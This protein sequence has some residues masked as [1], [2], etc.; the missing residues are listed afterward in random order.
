MTI[1]SVATIA[2][3]RLTA[4]DDKQA[5]DD[6]RYD[7]PSGVRV[8]AAFRTSV[9]DRKLG[10]ARAAEPEAGLHEVRSD[11]TPG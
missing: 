8:E 3:L 11:A 6:I 7:A 2:I 5:R 1:L 9:P 4:Q 10:H